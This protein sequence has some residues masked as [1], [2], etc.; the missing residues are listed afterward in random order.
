MKSAESI[1]ARAKSWLRAATSR[2]RL[3]REMDEELA[4]HLEKYT[5]QLIRQGLN[6]QE[7]ARRARME[8]GAIAVQKEEM[9]ASL[10]LRL[11]DDL[12]ADLRYAFRM[13]LKSPG[14]TAIAVGSLALGIGANTAIFSVARQVLLD[15]L[16]VP[17]PGELRLFS[18]TSPKHS[19]AHHVWGD[20]DNPGNGNVT[21]TSFPYPV[22]QQLREQNKVLQDLFAFKGTG[23]LTATVDGEAEVVQGEMVSGNYYQALGITPALGRPIRPGDDAV[24]GSG[25]VVVISDDYWAKR[26]SRLPSVIGKAIAINSKLFTIVGVNPANFTGAKNTHASPELFVPFSVQPLIL[27][28]PGSVLDDTGLWWMQIM[29]R[30][31]AGVPDRTA[32]AALDTA[33][34][35]AVRAFAHPKKDEAIPQLTLVDG[36]RGMNETG[37]AM[38]RPVYVLLAL[39]GLVLLL[40][41]ANIANPLLARSAARQREMGVRL[42]LGARRSRIL[43]QVLTES[44]LLSLLGGAAGFLLGY[45]G[46]NAIPRLMT[47]H[48]ESN[49]FDSRFDWMIFTFTA[50]ISILTGLAFGLAPAWRANAD[51][52][53]LRP[54]G[55]RANHNPPA[56][57]HRRK[58]DRCLSGSALHSAG[59]GRPSVRSH[60]G[61]SRRH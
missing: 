56:Q 53:E 19:V 11:W 9:R 6:P 33:F 50:G 26:F 1:F 13:L 49:S 40:A 48:W 30:S 18:W 36:S 55:Q 39:A 21:S 47:S 34:Q 28:R 2:S 38:A 52:G 8:L 42:A 23:R 45:L 31:K 60:A 27:P 44:L 46:R 35:A 22:Y 4:F 10:G 14:F 59:G 3:E 15:R 61:E 25:A 12:R 16:A 54:E 41:C 17:H 37:S 51:A 5:E 57:G 29:A 43:R 7:A 20:W 24:P 32:Q 58:D